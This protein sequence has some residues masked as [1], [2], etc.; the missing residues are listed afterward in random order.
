MS[1]KNSFVGLAGLV[2]MNMVM[3]I[4]E[5]LH[6]SATIE[7]ETEPLE[8]V[9]EIVV[10]LHDDY[11]SPDSITIAKEETTKLLLENVGQKEHTFTVEKLGIDVE[12]KPGEQKT[13]TV[14]PEEPGTYEL[15]CRYHE[16]EGMVGEVIVE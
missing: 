16:K 8:T 2:V 12:V 1:I 5:P 11:F 10:E 15:I 9:T 13:I 3:S 14:K 6:V 4:L 7:V